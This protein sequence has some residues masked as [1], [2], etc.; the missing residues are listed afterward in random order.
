MP[1]LQSSLKSTMG[2]TTFAPPAICAESTA[3]W[4]PVVRP[5]SAD[6]HPPQFACTRRIRR[7]FTAE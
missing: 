3:E 1:A 4:R 6:V 7:R 5:L 2:E